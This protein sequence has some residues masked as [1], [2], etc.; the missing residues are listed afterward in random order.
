MVDGDTDCCLEDVRVL[1]GDQL[2]DAVG[3]YEVVEVEVEVDVAVVVG[4][5][6][7]HSFKAS[8]HPN[9]ALRHVAISKPHPTPVG[10]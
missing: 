3:V 8:S 6:P 1:D 2:S 10:D 5:M 9:P 4:S 7:A